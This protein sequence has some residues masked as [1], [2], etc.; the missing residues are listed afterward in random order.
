M[1]IEIS[2]ITAPKAEKYRDMLSKHFARKVTVDQT[3]KLTSVVNFPMGECRIHA[4][5]DQLSFHCHAENDQAL[6]A[7]KS[8]IDR[9]IPLLKDIRDI[10]LEWQRE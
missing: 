10:Q 2:K 9:H 4:F 1:P 6:E 8:V 7:V 3:D 5:D